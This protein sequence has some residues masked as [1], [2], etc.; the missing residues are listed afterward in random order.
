VEVQSTSQTLKTAYAPRSSSQHGQSGGEINRD[1][2]PVA[3]EPFVQEYFRQARK[4][5]ASA[6]APASA[7]ASAPS[8]AKKQ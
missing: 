8:H 5:D 7:P 4:Q 1:E 6:P 3:M 2:I